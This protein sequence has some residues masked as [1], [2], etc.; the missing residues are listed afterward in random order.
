MHVACGMFPGQSCTRA[1]LAGTVPSTVMESLCPGKPMNWSR[2][3]RRLVRDIET[4]A[5]DYAVWTVAQE[6]RHFLL[7]LQYSTYNT[8]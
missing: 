7:D 5:Q 1:R 6:I 3:V 4:W 8:V 2:A